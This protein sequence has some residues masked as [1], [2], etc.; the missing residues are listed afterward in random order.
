LAKVLERQDTLTAEDRKELEGVLNKA[1]ALLE[2]QYVGIP[3]RLG[4]RSFPVTEGDK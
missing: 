1:N 3:K 2:G 4:V